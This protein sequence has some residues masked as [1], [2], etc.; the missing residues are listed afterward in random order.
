MTENNRRPSD[1]H[2]CMCSSFFLQLTIIR[3]PLIFSYSD[4]IHTTFVVVCFESNLFAKLPF[5]CCFKRQMHI[6]GI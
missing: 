1:K 4:L 6:V 2:V 3:F 5:V